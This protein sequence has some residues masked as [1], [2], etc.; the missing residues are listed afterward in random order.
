MLIAPPLLLH[1]LRISTT[2]S[3]VFFSVVATIRRL[4]GG[5]LLLPTAIG[6][7][8]SVV[9]MVGVVG[10]CQG[11]GRGEWRHSPSKIP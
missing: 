4:A 8:R 2:I 1:R 3:T 11:G 7:W 6:S 10:W 9:G 5:A